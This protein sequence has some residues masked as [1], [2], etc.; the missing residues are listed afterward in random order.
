[1]SAKND[2]LPV[3]VAPES[4]DGG[5]ITYANEVIAI[6]SGIAAKRDRGSPAW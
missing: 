5:T 3:D 6:I 2:M 1:M 4:A